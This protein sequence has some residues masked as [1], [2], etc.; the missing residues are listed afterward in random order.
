MDR[1]SDIYDR[2]HAETAVSYAYLRH[3]AVSLG[4]HHQYIHQNQRE[5][6][7]ESLLATEALVADEV[8]RKRRNT[9]EI[10]EQRKK[11][12]L[13]FAPVEDYLEQQWQNGVK[14]MVDVGLER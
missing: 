2:Q 13:D 8:D 10:E 9:H 3:R 7:S 6:H 4:A 14:S 12:Q 1:Y 5:R 11:Q